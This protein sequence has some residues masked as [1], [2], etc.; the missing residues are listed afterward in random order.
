MHMLQAD[1]VEMRGGVS[2][3][4]NCKHNINRYRPLPLLCLC[5]SAGSLGLAGPSALYTLVHLERLP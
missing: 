5:S 1:K 2:S 4:D 3:D